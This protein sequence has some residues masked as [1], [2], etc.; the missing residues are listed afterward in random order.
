MNTFN[1]I[2]EVGDT[3]GSL[4]YLEGTKGVVVKIE[5]GKYFIGKK[6]H[7]HYTFAKARLISK[8]VKQD[9]VGYELL[10]DLPGIP[11]GTK[12]T[13]RQGGCYFTHSIEGS[14]N[15]K[16]QQLQD[17]TWFKPIY[18]AKEVVV[19]I[20]GGREVTVADNNI[21]MIGGSFDL[22][23]FNSVRDFII[24]G[25]MIVNGFSIKHHSV[26][27]GCQEFTKQ[28]IELVYQAIQNIK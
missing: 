16:E 28:D 23:H 1:E 14:I 21:K 15:F 6:A 2:I 10:K 24:N 3:I 4:K 9:I 25:N 27:V 8:S 18:K 11:A 7:E 26:T 5:D 19:K 13:L 20:S 22:F 17:T 12:S